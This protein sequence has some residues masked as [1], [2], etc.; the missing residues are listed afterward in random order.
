MNRTINNTLK[1]LQKQAETTPDAVVLYSGGKDSIALLD[2]AMRAFRSVLPLHFSPMPGL[3]LT[4]LLVSETKRIWNV[5]VECVQ[6]PVRLEDVCNEIYC[7][8]G[9]ESELAAYDYTR[10]EVVLALKGLKGESYCVLDGQRSDEFF[11][12][13]MAM[14]RSPMSWRLHPLAKWK[15]RDVLAWLKS[16]KLPFYLGNPPQGKGAVC[17]WD[18][19]LEWMRTEHAEDYKQW[20]KLFPF[21]EAARW[22]KMWFGDCVYTGG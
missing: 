1:S 22:R 3:N 10:D 5:D 12:R 15:T 8:A 2:I 11:S 14:N 18:Y 6:D 13:R 19:S 4:R 20:Q 17:N 7:V 9:T 21:C 16:H